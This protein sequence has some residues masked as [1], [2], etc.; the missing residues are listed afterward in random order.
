MRVRV[1]RGVASERQERLSAALCGMH[2]SLF[3]TLNSIGWDPSGIGGARLPLT[4]YALLPRMAH[5]VRF[6]MMQLSWR[7]LVHAVVSLLLNA[8]LWSNPL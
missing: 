3:R 8:D 7:Q 6:L 4:P 2:Y 5:A 1:G